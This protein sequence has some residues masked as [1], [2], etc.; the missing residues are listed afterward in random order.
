MKTN[1]FNYKLPGNGCGTFKIVFPGPFYLEYENKQF[2]LCHV[3][4]H[5]MCERIKEIENELNMYGIVWNG[6]TTSTHVC[7]YMTGLIHDVKKMINKFLDCIMNYSISEEVFNREIKIIKEEYYGYYTIPNEIFRYNFNLKKFGMYEPIG[8]IENIENFTY[9]EMLEFKNKYFNKPLLLCYAHPKT[10]KDISIEQISVPIEFSSEYPIKEFFLGDYN[11]HE[12]IEN[13]PNENNSIIR[14]YTV[15]DV[16][17]SKDDAMLYLFSRII[18]YGLSSPLYQEFREK[19]GD[20]YSITRNQMIINEKQI[21]FLIDLTTTKDPEPIKDKLEKFFDS[22]DKYI[23]R[24]TFKFGYKNIQ[25][26]MKMDECLS[27]DCDFEKRTLEYK[28]YFLSKD[29]KIEYDEFVNFVKK[30]K[31]SKKYIV[32]NKDHEF[33]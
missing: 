18:G 11:E 4:E 1:L 16:D 29:N 9:N 19:H 20:V 8:S 23:N 21:I 32:T 6:L 7:F 31:N 25:N 3:I 24:E 12:T 2:G 26:A 14:F 5:C 17:S 30:I 33:Q 22:V 27:I 13:D 10:S 15:L 28:K